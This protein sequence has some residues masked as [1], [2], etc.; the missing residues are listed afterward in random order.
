[1]IALP[2]RKAEKERGRLCFPK[3]FWCKRGEGEAGLCL[4]SP[5]LWG[6]MGHSFPGSQDTSH[7]NKWL[8]SM[9]LHSSTSILCDRILQCCCVFTRVGGNK[10]NDIYEPVAGSNASLHV[11]L[12]IYV[13]VWY[14]YSQT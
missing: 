11:D 14:I 5:V 7:I 12:H 2:E 1:M 4:T 10:F 8:H 13:S 3:T 6:G 9:I